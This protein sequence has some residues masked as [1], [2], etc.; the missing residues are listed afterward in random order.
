MHEA[1]IDDVIVQFAG[2]GVTTISDA[3]D[4]LGIDGQ[5]FGIRPLDY[6]FRICGRAFTVLMRPVAQAKGTVGD[7]IDDVSPGQV[8]AIDNGGRLDATVWG[9][10]LTLAASRRGIG[11]T[12][13]DGVC[14]DSRRSLEL[15]YPIFSRGVYMRTGKDRVQADAYQ[16][17][18]TIGGV[19]VEPGD[20]LVGDADGVVVVPRSREEEVL[21]AAKEIAEAEDRIKEAVRQGLRLD[22]ARRQFGYFQ[23]QR[24]RE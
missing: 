2:L 14:R 6:R 17:A 8:V 12:V 23:L 21:A 11:G 5:C 13:I 4:R 18:V 24:R 19:R 16:V 10:I 7:F 22:E 15:S 1:S 9:D 20:V 3:L